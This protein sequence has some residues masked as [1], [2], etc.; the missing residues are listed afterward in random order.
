[1]PQAVVAA[2]AFIYGTVGTAAAAVGASSATAAAIATAAVTT[3]T[4][5]ASVALMAGI[6][7]VVANQ[8]K[9]RPQGGLIRLTVNPDEPRRLQIGK[10]M[11]GGVLVDWYVTGSKNQNL[12]MVVYL[13]EGPMGNITKVY[14]GGRVVYSSPIAHG[15]RT[16][17]P[18][19]RSGGDRLW[20]TYYDGRV[21][22]TADSYLVGKGLGWNSN[23]VGTGCAYAV[24]EA[25]WDSDNMTSPPQI[26]FEIEGA[27]LYDRRLDT[28]AGGSGA[29]RLTNPATWAASDNPAVALDHYLLGRYNGDVKTFGVGL[30]AAD[31]PYADFAALANLND[32]SVTLSYG[33]TQ[34]RYVANG[35]LF[36]DR[37]FS[38]TI[39]DLCRAMNARPAD[40]GG[41]I[42]I[43]DGEEKTPVLTIA[44]ED[45]IEA[46]PEQYLPKRTWG[47]LV[48]V[49]HGVYQSPA[50]NYQAIGYPRVENASWLTLD[51]GTAKEATLDLEMETNAERAQR[52]AWLYAKRERRQARLSGAYALRCIELEQGDWFIRSGGIFGAGKTF[53]VIDRVL[54]PRTMTVSISAFEVDASDTAWTTDIPVDAPPDAISS[55]DALQTMEVP[56]LTV[57]GVTLSG[58]AAEIPAIRVQWTAPTDPRVRQIVIEAVPQ[59]GGVPTSAVVDAVTAEVVFTSGIT[60]DTDYFVR[61]RFVGQ[62]IPSAWSSTFSVTTLGDYSVGTATSVPWSGVTGTGKPADNADVTSANTAAAIAGQGWGA[63]AAEAAASNVFVNTNLALNGSLSADPGAVGW[64]YNRTSVIGPRIEISLSSQIYYLPLCRF[65]C[66]ATSQYTVSAQMFRTGSVGNVYIQIEWRNS[67]DVVIGYSGAISFDPDTYSRKAITGVAPTGAVYGY[68]F[69]GTDT[70][71]TG[72]FDISRVQAELGPF[73]TAYSDEQTGARIG[74]MTDGADPTASN[75]AA[76]IAGQGALATLSTAGTGQIAANAVTNSEGASTAGATTLTAHTWTSV[77]SVS[78]TTTGGPV[79]VAYN[80]VN[81]ITT[82]GL[83]YP[84]AQAKLLRGATEIRAAHTASFPIY[85]GAGGMVCGG[86]YSGSIIDEPAAGTYTYHLYI[87]LTNAAGS[88]TDFITKTVESRSIYVTEFKR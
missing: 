85:D 14:G 46:V 55:T 25:Q 42:G 30:P 38:D 63:T 80:S 62:F 88:G 56:A 28:T 10:R 48:N 72:Y 33:G 53:E 35:F 87:K 64:T 9:P 37:T 54:D 29:H 77:I 18:N 40:F 59:A 73:E 31:V 20:I 17:I 11:N 61:A 86:A 6:N 26:S 47:D 13:G 78:I 70:P 68:A 52:L 69:F 65:V 50:Q 34:K 1:M 58:T 41:R 84:L 36:A 23:C 7:A 32:E 81:Y 4:A 5:A 15:T 49:V 27:K 24:I 71:Q 74:T 3:A 39:K 66:A 67:S 12:F 21:G 57:T 79:F 2:Q 19:Y 60:D 83:T 76:A 16:V 82:T 43:I 8:N 44:D 51:G 75:T 22:Q 45:V